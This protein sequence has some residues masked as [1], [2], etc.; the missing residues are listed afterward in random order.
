MLP[1]LLTAFTVAVPFVWNGN[2]GVSSHTSWKPM[3]SQMSSALVRLGLEEV[4]N[5]HGWFNWKSNLVWLCGELCSFKESHFGRN[6]K[7]FMTLI[8]M[9]MRQYIY[10]IL[11]VP[12]G[13]GRD[14]WD[15]KRQLKEETPFVRKKNDPKRDD[16]LTRKG[17]R[18]PS[19]KQTHVPVFS[20]TFHLSSLQF[21]LGLETTFHPEPREKP[22]VWGFNTNRDT[23]L[24]QPLVL[25]R[26]QGNG[27]R[28]ATPC[29]PNERD[30]HQS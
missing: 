24:R 15:D 21:V 19:Q 18:E 29:V 30:K 9:R 8:S 22:C 10:W 3:C 28:W 20:N 14:F 13:L 12:L 11:H 6:T 23:S 17:L 27:N 16:L 5:R 7:E 4:S 1:R 2:E 25:A 26:R